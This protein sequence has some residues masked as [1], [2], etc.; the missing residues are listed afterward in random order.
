MNN[1]IATIIVNT[2]PS[3]T[4][5]Y[6]WIPEGITDNVVPGLDILLTY[7]QS[8]HA[9]LT[10][11]QNSITNINTTIGN[12]IQNVQTEINN[13]RITNPQNVSKE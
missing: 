5:N 3:L 6:L 13:I 2:V 1:K 10:A 4:E 7:F 12:E 9:T 11:L 8:K